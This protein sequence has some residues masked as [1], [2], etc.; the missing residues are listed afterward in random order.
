[1]GKTPRSCERRLTSPACGNG[2]TAGP[3]QGDY[4]SGRG[5]LGNGYCPRGGG[6]GRGAT[7]L[8]QGDRNGVAQGSGGSGG[9]VFV[10]APS[11]TEPPPVG[12]DTAWAIAASHPRLSRRVY[13]ICSGYH[14]QKIALK[15]NIDN[16]YM[17]AIIMYLAA[18][19]I[20]SISTARRCHDCYLKGADVSPLGETVSISQHSCCRRKVIKVSRD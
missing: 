12:E 20:Y 10:H 8:T 4:G 19:K 5:A 15:W 16:E 7:G 18:F 6:S 13:G 14:S 2:P 1:M 3:T 9:G 17:P 11:P